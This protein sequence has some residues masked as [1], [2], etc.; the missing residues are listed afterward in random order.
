MI[1]K[2]DTSVVIYRIEYNGSIL[3]V[4]GNIYPN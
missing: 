1:N 2:D 3:G 4:I